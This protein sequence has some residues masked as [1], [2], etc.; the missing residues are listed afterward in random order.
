MVDKMIWD[1]TEMRKCWNEHS[2]W[3]ISY[4]NDNGIMSGTETSSILNI[5]IQEKK[6]WKNA[7]R[8]LKNDKIAEVYSLMEEMLKYMVCS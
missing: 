8:K 6:W 4:E 5:I 2:I 7:T 1:L 3:E